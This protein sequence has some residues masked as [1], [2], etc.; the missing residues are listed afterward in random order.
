MLHAELGA[1]L[2][3]HVT[4]GKMMV[5]CPQSRAGQVLQKVFW[6]AHIVMHLLGT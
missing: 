5:T 1:R 2:N 3:V 6:N 4:S